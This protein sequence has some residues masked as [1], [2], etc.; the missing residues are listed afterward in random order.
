MSFIGG[1]SQI[2]G[3]I[4]DDIVRHKAE[5]FDITGSDSRQAFKT[6]AFKG[7]HGHISAKSQC[8]MAMIS[9]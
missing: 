8:F 4:N 3:K 1:H 2:H 7:L 9:F 5:S 6:V